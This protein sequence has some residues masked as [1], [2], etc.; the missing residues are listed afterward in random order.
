[1]YFIRLKATVTAAFV[2]FDSLCLLWPFGG[3]WE[4]RK[5]REQPC[6]EKQHIGQT[7]E[8]LGSHT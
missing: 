4:C 2:P 8:S 5:R 6:G 1:M 7:P 3:L